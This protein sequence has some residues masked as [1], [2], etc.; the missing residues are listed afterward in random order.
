MDCY[1]HRPDDDRCDGGLPDRRDT[2]AGCLPGN[3][4]GHERI[5]VG[6][7]TARG[8]Q[9]LQGTLAGVGTYSGTSSSASGSSFS[10][11]VPL[12]GG[13]VN[14][15]YY[16]VRELGDFCNEIGSWSSG[17]NGECAGTA[18]CNRDDDITP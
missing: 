11:G 10:D 4:P 14:G 18:T 2:A 12:P 6:W 16:V 13:T 15:K 17:G 3:D 1:L 9:L 5:H 7:S 8:F